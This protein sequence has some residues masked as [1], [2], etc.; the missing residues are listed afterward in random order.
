[1]QRA[2]GHGFSIKI[3]HKQNEV[4]IHLLYIYIYQILIQVH[5]ISISKKLPERTRTKYCQHFDKCRQ[6]LTLVELVTRVSTFLTRHQC[7]HYPPPSTRAGNIFNK[8]VN[9]YGL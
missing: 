4:D 1:M 5:G 7:P 8:K 2:G 6:Q 9:I 3:F